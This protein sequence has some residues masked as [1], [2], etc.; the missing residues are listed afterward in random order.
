[1]RNPHINHQQKIKLKIGRRQSL[2]IHYNSQTNPT[3]IIRTSFLTKLFPGQTFVPGAPQSHLTHACLSDILVCVVVEGGPNAAQAPRWVRNKEAESGMRR[4]EVPDRSQTLEV[5]YG[6]YCVV[7]GGWIWKY[8]IFIFTIF[9][10]YV[11][12]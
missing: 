5:A 6:V 10:L 12:H 11:F 2:K 4:L 7:P 1:M 8:V 9:S 3:N